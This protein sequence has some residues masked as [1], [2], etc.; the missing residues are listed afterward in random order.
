[1]KISSLKISPETLRLI[2]G[3]AREP[4]I[5][6]LHPDALMILDAARLRGRITTGEAGGLTGAPRPT[7]KTRLS[8][9]VKRG[10]L[11]RQGKG[12]GLG[13]VCRS[14]SLFPQLKNHNLPSV[15]S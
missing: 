8:E 1:M 2:G 6:G 3:I 7:V 11:K 5:E 9:L 10:L 13:M 14:G 15:I 12:E 4:Q